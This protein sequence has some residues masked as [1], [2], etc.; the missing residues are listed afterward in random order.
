MDPDT[1]RVKST[2]RQ[3]SDATRR[4]II[5][6]AHQ[7]FIARGF[8]GATV[9]G[10]A[11]RAGV[12]SQTVYF[13]FHT[14]PELISAVIDSAVLGEDDPRPPQAQPWWTAMMQE[15]D[16]A[17]ALRIFIRGAGPLFAR[18]SA[19]S[20]VLRAA[21]LTDNEVRRTH[22]HHENLR[23]DGFGQVLEILA[24]KG[25]L[26]A[27]RPIDQLTEAFMTVYGDSTYHQL[28]VECGWSHDQ[29]MAWLCDVLPDM[30]L[31]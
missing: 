5:T 28:A 16:A 8:H 31:T 1:L 22:Q 26:R 15:P 11:A 12:A 2:R 18:A 3:K 20:E 21:A 24:E 4:K 17:E 23:R 29:I 30:L 14:K 9:A 25:A 6:A 7:E 19:I 27:D 13:V 10:I